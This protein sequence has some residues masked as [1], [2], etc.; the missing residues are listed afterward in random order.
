MADNPG[1]RD[2]TRKMFKDMYSKRFGDETT[3]ADYL[4]FI[5]GDC[6]SWYKDAPATYKSETSVSRLKSMMNN[7]LNEAKYPAVASNVPGDRRAAVRVA[8]RDNLKALVASGYFRPRKGRRA[9]L[10]ADVSVESSS[11]SGGDVAD[12]P[13]D[14]LCDVGG[15]DLRVENIKLK[16]MLS[17]TKE[18]VI[19]LV[20]AADINNSWKPFIKMLIERVV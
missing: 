8:M 7:L 15:N 17:E 6:E 5:V 12:L 18:I 2:D 10:A 4:D 9:A 19:Q 1:E 14:L 20:E 11:S 13:D 16:K 3:F